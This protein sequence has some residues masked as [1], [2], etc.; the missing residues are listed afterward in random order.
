[1]MDAFAQQWNSHCG[2]KAS[3]IEISYR[4]YD[5]MINLA[6]LNK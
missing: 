2:A 6:K 1:M 3:I 4:Y 5:N